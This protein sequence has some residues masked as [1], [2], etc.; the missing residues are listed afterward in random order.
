MHRNDTFEHLNV[1]YSTTISKSA[2]EI[3][4]RDW[5]VYVRVV[6]QS[7]EQYQVM[8]PLMKTDLKRFCMCQRI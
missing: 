7:S 2:S 6:W 4:C 8:S 3:C 5:W 1:K